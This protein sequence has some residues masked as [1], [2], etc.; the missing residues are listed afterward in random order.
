MDQVAV[1]AHLGAAVEAQQHRQHRRIG[2]VAA[3]V[4]IFGAVGEIEQRGEVFGDHHTAVQAQKGGDAA[5]AQWLEPG[6]GIAIAEQDREHGAEE[7]Q[8]RGSGTLPG[9][10]QSRLRVAAA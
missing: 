9:R 5:P 3:L 8:G 10:S 6:I 1:F 2:E 7:A 4:G